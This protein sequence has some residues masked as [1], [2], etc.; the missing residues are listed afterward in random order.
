MLDIAKARLT[1]K[2]E[3]VLKA[4]DEVRQDV[5]EFMRKALKRFKGMSTE[6]IQCIALEIAVLGTKGLGINDSK[7]T[8]IID[9]LPGEFTALELVSIMYAAFQQFA[10]ESD[11]GIDLGVENRVATRG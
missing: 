10:P 6:D 4:N 1:A 2:S 7:K 5:V 3:S 9:S 8:Y 11:I